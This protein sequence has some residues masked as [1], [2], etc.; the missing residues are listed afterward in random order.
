MVGVMDSFLNCPV[1]EL[2]LWHVLISCCVIHL[3]IQLISNWV[4]QGPK[5]LVAMNTCYPKARLGVAPQDLVQGIIHGAL[6]PVFQRN[7][8]SE[9]NASL[10]DVR[11]GCPFTYMMSMHSIKFLC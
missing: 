4:H 1:V 2:C 10:M 9:A 7:K 6:S 8:R 3:Y 11:R 5:F